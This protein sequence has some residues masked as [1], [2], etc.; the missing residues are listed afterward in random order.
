MLVAAADGRQR[1]AIG[2]AP[3]APLNFAAARAPLDAWVAVAEARRAGRRCVADGWPGWRRMRFAHA[4]AGAGGAGCKR[5][6]R[7]LTGWACVG[8]V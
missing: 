3:L 5:A 8:R 7:A 4:P 6:R 1:R 2:C